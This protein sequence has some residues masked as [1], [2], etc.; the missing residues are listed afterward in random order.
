MTRPESARAFLAATS[1]AVLAVSPRMSIVEARVEC[2]AILAADPDAH[3]MAWLS[4]AELAH[5]G[6]VHLHEGRVAAGFDAALAR[7][8]GLTCREWADRNPFVPLPPPDRLH[9]GTEDNHAPS[10]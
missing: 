10:L 4:A 9:N 7:E 1:P 5:H 2:R 6:A 8:P 3:P